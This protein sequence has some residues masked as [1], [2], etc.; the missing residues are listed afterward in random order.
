[1]VV[2]ARTYDLGCRWASGNAFRKR[3]WT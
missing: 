1:M 3:I 2:K